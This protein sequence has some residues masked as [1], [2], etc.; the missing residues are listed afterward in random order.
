MLQKIGEGPETGCFV[1][2]K[3]IY[4]SHYFLANTEFY[5]LLPR[6]SDP[7]GFYLAHALHAR[8]DPPRRFRGLLLGRIKEASRGGIEEDLERT[9]KQ[10]ESK[11]T[12]P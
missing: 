10:L 1:A 5:T 11:P 3:H 7:K 2:M 8:I 6:A 9:R 4:D 12:V